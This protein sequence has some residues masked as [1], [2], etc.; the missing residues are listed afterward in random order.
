MNIVILSRN[1]ALYSTQS[2]VTAAR[3]RN[4][5]VRVI[6]YMAC[7]L[8]I[9]S[10]K[11]MIYFNNQPV[12]NV[13]AVIPRIGTSGTTYGAAVLR[14]FEHQGVVL[15]LNA[16]PL[17]NARD[18]LSCLQILGSKGIGV[19]K[20][21]FISNLYTIPYLLDQ[22]DSYPV[23]IKLLSGTQGM[24]VILAENR[25]NAESVL[26]AFQVVKEKVLLQ[27]FI[28]EAKGADIRAF[29]VDGE[30]VGAMK[31]Q[32]REGDFRS[33]LHRGGTS[34]KIRLTAAEEET[35]L[36]SA[37]ILGL[38]IAGVDMLKTHN[39]PVVMEV[40][41]SPGLEGIEGTTGVDIAGKI[42]KFIERQRI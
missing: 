26:E 36:R 40:N 12:I 33:N 23:I 13:D 8:I 2:L 41:A 18:K 32:A 42:I 37:E 4:H 28:K 22:M 27:K 24:G 21:I 30:V 11:S 17:L 14:Q 1:A 3:R 35:A 15:T 25:S 10:G 6:D 20:T 34:E 29:V 31:R 38:K 19:P 5:Y 16:E 9:E 7:D 39:G